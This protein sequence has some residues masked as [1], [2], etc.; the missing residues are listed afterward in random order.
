MPSYLLPRLLV[1]LLVGIS[2]TL[3][4]VAKEPL[5]HH[6]CQVESFTDSVQLP[7]CSTKAIPIETTHCRGQ[8]YS[9]DSLI[10]DWQYVPTHY[11][12]QRRMTCCS[13]NHTI[14]YEKRIT[15][16]NRQLRTLQYRIITRCDCRTCSD[17][18]VESIDLKH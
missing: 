16:D 5:V 18:C 11:R 12:H 17:K 15:C 1:F 2:L 9:E 8:C 7:D 4:A 6:H 3:L 10:Y 13:P 14:P